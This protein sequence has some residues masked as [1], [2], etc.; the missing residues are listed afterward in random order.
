MPITFPDVA[1]RS[2]LVAETIHLKFICVPLK[3]AYL[4]VEFSVE[5]KVI[6]TLPKADKLPFVRFC[7]TFNLKAKL[8]AHGQLTHKIIIKQEVS[9]ALHHQVLTAS[10]SDSVTRPHERQE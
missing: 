2:I 4:L 7:V 8:D 9:L 1:I 10:Y 5:I 6:A 3:T